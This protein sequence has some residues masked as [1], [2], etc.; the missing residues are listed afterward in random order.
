[1]RHVAFRVARSGETRIRLE[2]RRP[3]QDDGPAAATFE[4]TVSATGSLTGD[5]EQG[6]VEDQKRAVLAGGRAA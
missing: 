6:L 2:K 3:W 5:A 4:A 1:M